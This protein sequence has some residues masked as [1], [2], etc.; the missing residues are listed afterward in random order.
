M[1]KVTRGECKRDGKND[2]DGDTTR[3]RQIV[4][5]TAEERTN[6]RKGGNEAQVQ[7]AQRGNLNAAVDK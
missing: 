1:M 3:E 7:L 2:D 5:A 4:R 6:A